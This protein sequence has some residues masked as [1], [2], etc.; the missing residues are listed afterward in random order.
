MR[1]RALLLGAL[2]L[3]A[4]PTTGA[5]QATPCPEGARPLLTRDAS[6][7]DLYDGFKHGI[8]GERARR[9]FSAAV[10]YSL[11]ERWEGITQL[12]QLAAADSTF[13]GFVLA[14]FRD[15]ADARRL[16]SIVHDAAGHCPKGDKALCARIVEAARPP[17]DSS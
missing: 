15:S 14:Q 8:C 12:N 2:L 11:D 3:A 16:K 10:M 1:R 17:T 13:L 9:A 5:A 6:W 7:G 4:V